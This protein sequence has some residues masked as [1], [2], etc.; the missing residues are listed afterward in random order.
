MHPAP[1]RGIDTTRPSVAR[2][3]D[4]W[5][6]GKDN[7]AV[8]RELAE[9]LLSLN[10]GMRQWARDN[11]AFLCAAAARAAHESGIDQFLDLGA[12]LP[13]SPAIHEAVREVSPGARFAYV[14]FDPVA[15]LHAQAL[16]RKQDGLVA[17]LADLTDTVAVLS[18]PDT[19]KTLDLGRPI[20]IILGG[21]AHFMSAPAMRDV[22]AGYLSQVPAGSWL[23]LSTARTESAQAETELKSAYTAAESYAHSAEDFRSFFDGTQIVPPGLREARR[24]IARMQAAPPADQLYSLC[25][26]GVKR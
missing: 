26:A 7:F 8:D 3:Y 18:H 19:G 17:I 22:V 15:V 4:Y 11:R 10:P 25:G 16:L 2:V 6:D 24:W 5:L 14:D 1:P 13:A 23:I 21:V 20:G 12:G 9:Q